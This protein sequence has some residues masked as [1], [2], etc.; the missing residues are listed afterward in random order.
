MLGHNSKAKKASN[1]G[2]PS[3]VNLLRNPAAPAAVPS[4]SI[5]MPSG[6]RSPETRS[7]VVTRPT[8][9]SSIAIPTA[10]EAAAQVPM[11]V[12][13]PAATPIAQPIDS[14]DPL[15][16]AR[17]RQDSSSVQPSTKLDSRSLD[18]AFHKA[19]AAT[20][21]D[22]VVAEPTLTPAVAPSL[23]PVASAVPNKPL[24]PESPKPIQPLEP[25]LENAAPLPTAKTADAKPSD[26]AIQSAPA[27]QSIVTP[28]APPP[29]V[30]STPVT[31]KE[32]TPAVAPAVPELPSKTDTADRPA[33]IGRGLDLPVA[34]L[35]TALMNE[36]QVLSPQ[37][38][39][40]PVPTPHSRKL[41]TRGEGSAAE[42]VPT[43][44]EP[45][46]R[47]APTLPVSKETAPAAV[48][49][50]AAEKPA[51]DPKPN[52]QQADRSN[53][54]TP[55][56]ASQVVADAPLPSTQPDAQPQLAQE[57]PAT[58]A[59]E[60]PTAATAA[61]P[62]PNGQKL[63]IPRLPKTAAPEANIP[64]QDK[65]LAAPNPSLPPPPVRDLAKPI[66]PVRMILNKSGASP[67]PYS[68]ASPQNSVMPNI[69]PT[70]PQAKPV[71]PPQPKPPAIAPSA[72]APATVPTVKP[73]TPLAPAKS[74]DSTSMAEKPMQRV[75]LSFTPG[76]D[77]LGANGEDS[78]RVLLRSMEANQSARLTITAYSSPVGGTTQGARRLALSRGLAVRAFLL[79]SGISS[80]RMDIRA[81]G[82][83]V[84]N[85][86][87][88]ADRVEVT[89]SG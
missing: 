7:L 43:S 15:V 50:S 77:N 20:K 62:E 2:I 72:P 61:A 3:P 9:Q 85:S 67:V 27:Q 5:S 33:Q 40:E 29:V 81:L 37:T 73:E 56:P 19:M 78:L 44:T 17:H 53:P 8:S 34:P 39:D 6:Y 35:A 12:D 66:P 83:P 69:Q 51:N 80:E 30:A 38:A 79:K 52:Q 1:Q 11:G 84:D 16:L 59:D 23:N 88:D 68:P 18:Q 75:R 70:V 54:A 89:T 41:F 10:P 24:E 32:A 14:R 64:D 63:R 22:S 4:S 74:T 58:K 36:P 82:T 47:A 86:D 65:M 31:P 49:E 21:S 71:A 46:M 60:S 45:A 55:P 87:K 42:P 25:Q 48:K 76:S 26:P 28:P 13:R 57:E